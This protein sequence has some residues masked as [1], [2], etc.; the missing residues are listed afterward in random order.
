MSVCSTVLQLDKKN[1]YKH[2][3]VP[4]CIV[5]VTVT[6]PMNTLH[7]CSHWCKHHHHLSLSQLQCKQSPGLFPS[8]IT[9]ALVFHVTG[10]RDGTGLQYRGIPTVQQL[11]P[12]L[13]TRLDSLTTVWCRSSECVWSNTSI[14]HTSV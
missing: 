5:T 4:L 9:P 10:H 12:P 14:F 2:H 11:H 3:A 8:H 13:A 1:A 6:T 7:R